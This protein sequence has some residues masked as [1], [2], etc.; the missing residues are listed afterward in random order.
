MKRRPVGIGIVGGGLMGR[1]IASAF[2]RWR[3]LTDVAVE[4]LLLGVADVNP[5]ALE[6]LDD[7]RTLLTLDYRELLD[8]TDV[9]ILYVAVPH[10]L[11]AKTVPV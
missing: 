1:E 5:A 10:N 11:H 3:A 8:R 7:G 6:W 2:A 4:P 9:E